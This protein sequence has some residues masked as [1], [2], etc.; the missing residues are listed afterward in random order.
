MAEVY[1]TSYDIDAIV[2]EAREYGDVDFGDNDSNDVVRAIYET[3][4]H[5][6]SPRELQYEMPNLTL[7]YLA[8]LIQKRMAAKHEPHED[9]PCEIEIQDSKENEDWILF[10]VKVHDGIQPDPTVSIEF[11]RVGGRDNVEYNE[12]QVKRL[13]WQTKKHADEIRKAYSMLLLAF[14]G[15]ESIP[16]LEH[17][18]EETT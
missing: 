17:E 9:V 14:D 13:T 8:D 15:L 12:R 2:A 10:S 4:Q 18:R 3:M 7:L 6:D 11:P 16:E 5:P 1:L